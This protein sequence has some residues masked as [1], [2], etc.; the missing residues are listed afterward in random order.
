MH[1][2]TKTNTLFTKKYNN[3]KNMN[4]Y[5][6]YI[7]KESSSS[8]SSSSSLSDRELAN[9]LFTEQTMNTDS[10]ATQHEL[11]KNV[12]WLGHAIC[13]TAPPKMSSSPRKIT[14]PTKLSSECFVPVTHSILKSTSAPLEVPE[15]HGEMITVQGETGVLANR[16]DLINW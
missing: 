15:V 14:K 16:Q 6:P 9:E 13:S 11:K 7:L 12:S 4:I 1:N 3:N 5:A 8:S 2:N 10:T